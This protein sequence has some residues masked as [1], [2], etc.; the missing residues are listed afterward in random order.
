MNLLPELP[1][2]MT[3]REAAD[4]MLAH[5]EALYGWLSGEI[6][7]GGIRLRPGDEPVWWMKCGPGVARA[8]CGMIEEAT[9]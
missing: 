7:G 2:E 5:T 3:A 6:G 4:E 8:L 1:Q 9:C